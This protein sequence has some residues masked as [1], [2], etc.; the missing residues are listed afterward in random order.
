MD[1][2][3]ETSPKGQK[4]WGAPIIVLAVLVLALGA[5]S[6]VALVKVTALKRDVREAQQ[7]VENL[8]QWVEVL[9]ISDTI[10]LASLKETPTLQDIETALFLGQL[11][12]PARAISTPM[13]CGGRTAVWT[14]IQ[15]GLGCSAE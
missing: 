12:I 5:V 10:F 11:E 9:R 13:F 4:S 7:R 1:T 3:Q 6:A 15:S 8:D 2:L 14:V